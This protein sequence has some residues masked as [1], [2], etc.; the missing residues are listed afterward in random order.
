MLPRV[1]HDVV[2]HKEMVVEDVDTIL[3]VG[4]LGGGRRDEEEARET[5]AR[6][7]RVELAQI[8][9]DRLNHS[10]DSYLHIE[11]RLPPSGQRMM[12]LDKGGDHRLLETDARR[13]SRTAAG[14]ESLEATR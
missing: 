11:R 6:R 14:L 13:C 10:L 4:V 12:K 9:R 1:V 3:G 7:R 8:H 2:H 5:S